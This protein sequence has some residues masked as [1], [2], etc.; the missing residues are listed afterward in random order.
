VVE[1]A[2]DNHM[3]NDNGSKSFQFTTS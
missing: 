2:H 1:P 3:Q